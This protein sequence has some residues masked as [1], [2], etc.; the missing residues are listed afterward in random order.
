MSTLLVHVAVGASPSWDRRTDP[1]FMC[2]SLPSPALVAALEAS[3]GV[4]T[5]TPLPALYYPTLAGA[6]L[7]F[8]LRPIVQARCDELAATLDA[9]FLPVFPKPC[10]RCLANATRMAT[11]GTALAD[12]RAARGGNELGRHGEPGGAPPEA[13]YDDDDDEPRPPGGRLPKTKYTNGRPRTFTVQIGPGG[14]PPLHVALAAMRADRA[15][16]PPDPRQVAS[17]AR[18][19][20]LAASGVT[21]LGLPEFAADVAAAIAA[22]RLA[23]D[24]RERALAT[25]GLARPTPI[26]VRQDV[27][28]EVEV[29]SPAARASSPKRTRARA[30]ASKPSKAKPSKAKA[31]RGARGDVANR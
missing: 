2:G 8:V 19:A 16:Q 6:G 22:G 13:A 12:R 7:D 26:E 29:E 21:S 14:A 18:M 30:I 23:A 24:W 1:G 15:A 11:A 28:A 25:A 20:Q 17:N 3:F 4:T 5:P 31:R 27:T 10:E 9:Q